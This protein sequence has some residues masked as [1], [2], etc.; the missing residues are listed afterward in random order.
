MFDRDKWQEIFSTIRKNKLRTAL[1]ALGVFWGI[2]MLVFILGMG[3]GLETGVFRNFGSGAKNI[4][5]V[6]T[7]KTSLPYKG[8]SPG[9]FIN[10]NLDDLDSIEENIDGV[11]SVS[12]RM[13]L[14]N[15]TI[16]YNEKS[17][18]YNCR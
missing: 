9:R 7:Y 3:N 10:L 15:R 6:W 5:F 16:S 11:G 2:F 13:Y 17:G 14:G 8:L 4:M 12:P 1:T 18:T